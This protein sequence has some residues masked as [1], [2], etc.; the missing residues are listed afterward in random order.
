MLEADVIINLPKPKTHRIAGYTAALKNMIGINTRKEYLPHHRKGPKEKKGDEY[1]GTHSLLKWINSNMNDLKNWALDKQIDFMVDACNEICRCTGKKLD[2]L[3]QDRKKFGM[4]YGNDTIWRTILD[5]NKIVYF[6]NKE[7]CICDEQ[8]RKV[9]HFG[10]MIV[11]GE[12]EGPLR[13]SYK[14]V[15]GILF[16]DNPVSF[17][18][19]VVKLM[20]FDYK[21]IP[22]LKNAL[23]DKCLI[24]EKT[25][26]IRLHSNEEDFDRV[27]NDIN[28][29]FRFEPSVG[30]RDYL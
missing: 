4:W 6:C 26:D 27:V 24:K 16:S 11:C 7:G 20:G 29:S 9:L 3:E 19:C 22:T 25:D 15:G 14:K 1:I 2:K 23:E 21:K 13:P 18:F 30:W 5:V 12:K 8:Q 17:D 10:D 28:Y